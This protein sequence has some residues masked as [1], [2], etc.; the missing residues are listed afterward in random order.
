MKANLICLIAL[1][2]FVGASEARR[3]RH[4][5]PHKIALGIVVRTFP[6]V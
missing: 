6:Q 3:T 1:I 5:E 4:R 2:I